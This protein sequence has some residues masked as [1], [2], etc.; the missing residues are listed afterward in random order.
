MGERS[1]LKS[2]RAGLAPMGKADA[3]SFSPSSPDEPSSVSPSENLTLSS[4]LLGALC[5]VVVEREE[6][7]LRLNPGDAVPS[8]RP[9]PPPLAVPRASSSTACGCT[10]CEGGVVLMRSSSAVTLYEIV[11][12]CDLAV[13]APDAFRPVRAQV[14]G[15][16]R[17]RREALT[18]NA[19]QCGNVVEGQ[20]SLHEVELVPPPEKWRGI[21]DM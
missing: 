2:S 13:R 11:W 5:S 1:S 9:A 20:P 15:S 21:I 7:E 12:D 17:R 19:T 6:G 18:A 4:S 3:A 10:S 8:A 14:V 16:S